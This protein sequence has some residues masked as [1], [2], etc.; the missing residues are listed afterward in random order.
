MS[1]ITITSDDVLTRL[2]GA[3]KASYQNA[4]RASGQSDPLP[5]IIAQVTDVVRGYV[6]AC[7]AN[8]LDIGGTI[9]PRLLAAAVDII[10]YRLTT[11]LPLTLTAAREQEYKDAI[12][13]LKDVAAC[14]FSVEDPNSS[15]PETSSQS[16]TPAICPKNL[17]FDRRDQEGA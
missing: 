8:E 5:E 3:E 2:A 13:L 4:A 11:R 17:H 7:A 10:R 1:W 16:S 9:P 14:K 15:D 6:A 12:S